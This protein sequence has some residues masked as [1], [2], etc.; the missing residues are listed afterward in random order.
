MFV[1]DTNVISELRKVRAAKA[2]RGVAEWAV[3]VPS[4]HLFISVM[5]VHELELG[6]LLAE[7]RDPRQGASLRQWLDE[8]VTVAFADRVLAIDGTV[9]KRAAALHDPDPAPLRDASIAGAALVHRM[10]VVTRNLRD[11]ER[12]EGLAVVNPWA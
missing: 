8:S 5:T 2:D 6:V 7:R 12:F 9:A 11:F 1:L 3:R 10:T 4:A